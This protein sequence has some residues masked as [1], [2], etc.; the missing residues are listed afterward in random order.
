MLEKQLEQKELF[1]A[2]EKKTEFGKRN[3]YLF[4]L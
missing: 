1:Y 4:P 3:D 2:K